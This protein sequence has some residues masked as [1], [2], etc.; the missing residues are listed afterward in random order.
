[1]SFWWFLIKEFLVSCHLGND[2]SN[3][4]MWDIPQPSSTHLN[5]PCS[6]FFFHHYPGPLV[7]GCWPMLPSAP[8]RA[9][10]W[11]PAVPSPNPCWTCWEPSASATVKSWWGTQGIP[12]DP[13]G[14]QG[15]QGGGTADLGLGR[16]FFCLGWGIG[17]PCFLGADLRKKTC[18]SSYSKMEK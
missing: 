8:A 18:F 12:Q 10:P 6:T 11:L 5:P 3:S 4:Q 9:P 16:F 7:T 17:N 1:M 13:R 15:I 14:P 2:V